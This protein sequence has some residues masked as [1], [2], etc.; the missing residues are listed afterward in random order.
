MV[1]G[2]RIGLRIGDR[3]R[4]TAVVL[5]ASNATV[6]AYLFRPATDGRRKS[7]LL[8]FVIELN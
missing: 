1:S 7:P 4:S 3:E 5:P 2:R 8:Q 6:T